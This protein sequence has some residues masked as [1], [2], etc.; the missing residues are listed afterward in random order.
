MLS[1][2]I[3]NYVERRPLERGA[4]PSLGMVLFAFVAISATMLIDRRL[5]R[6]A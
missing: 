2:A 1:V 3:F 4:H 5:S 6:I